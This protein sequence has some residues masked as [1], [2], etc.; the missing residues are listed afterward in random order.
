MT[1]IGPKQKS[2]G[3]E[4]VVVYAG[5][6]NLYPYMGAAA[7]S[8]L[9]H[10]GADHVYLLTEDTHFPEE[11]PD[12]VETVDVS[13]QSWILPS[14]PN[15]G[16]KWTYMTLMKA[17]LGRLFPALD[18]VLSLDVDTIVMGDMTPL[19]ETDL[20]DNYLGAVHDL[21]RLDPDYINGGVMLLNL[22]QLRAD[23]KDL[24]IIRQ[25]NRQR[26]EFCEQ[27]AISE[28]CRGRIKHLPGDYNASSWTVPP[29]GG[30]VI[31]HYAAERDWMQ[32]PLVQHWLHRSW[33]DALG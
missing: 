8:L 23:G 7:R 25:L 27:E 19:W 29:S 24:E 17:T 30:I 21:A 26:Y 11:L 22:R 18:R 5:T 9:A 2:N 28:L 16:T 1:T 20:G 14:S 3:G 15:Y 10:Q 6:R 4:R 33:A 12:C 13:G 32:E 31:R